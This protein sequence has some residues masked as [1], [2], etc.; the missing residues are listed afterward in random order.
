MH[1]NE[2]RQ[3]DNHSH[4]HDIEEVGFEFPLRAPLADKASCS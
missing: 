3:D 4:S 2:R 1:D